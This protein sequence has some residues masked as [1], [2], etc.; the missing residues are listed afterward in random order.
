MEAETVSELVRSLL[1]RRGVESPE[2]VSAF[3]SPDY[4]AHT[5]DPFL[6]VDMD[7]AAARVLD[8]MSAGE[9]IAVY[10]DFDCDGIPGASVLSDFFKK[11]GYGNFEVYLPHRDREGYGFH[12]EAIAQLAERRVKLIITVDV[13]TVAFDGVA[14]AK[15]KASTSS[16]PIIMRSPTELPEAFAIIESE[17]RALSFLRICAARQSRSSSCRRRSPKGR[18]AASSNS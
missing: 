9:R 12:T 10:A 11:I 8:A 13:G 4:A 2:A 16:S 3:L 14:F 7:K 6:L 15:R 18:S 1:A 17:A 5:H